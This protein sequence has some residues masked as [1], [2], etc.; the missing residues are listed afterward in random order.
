MTKFIVIASGKGGVGKTT[1][2]LNIGKVL[3]DFG[4][5][6]IVVDADLT[7]PNIGLHLGSPAVSSTLHDVLRGERSIKEVIYVHPSGLKVIPGSISMKDLERLESDNL[8]KVLRE[9]D[10]F[11]EIVLIDAA[12]GISKETIAAIKAADEMLVVVNP[13]M[14]SI[15][16]ALKTIKTAEK[17]GV[18]VIGVLVNRISNSR[19]ELSKKNIEALLEKKV[20][21]EIPEDEDMKKALKLKHPVLYS[22][23]GSKSSIPF[24]KLAALLIGQH[25]D[26]P[27]HPDSRFSGFLKKIGIKE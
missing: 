1:A 4:R 10:G 13:N 9:L 22:H 6:V 21:G 14:L 7:K 5:E 16:D 25:Y 3:A 27:L 26:A 23:P 12:P 19:D 24:K 2:V 17:H 8:G 11:A 20:I 15:T 18:K